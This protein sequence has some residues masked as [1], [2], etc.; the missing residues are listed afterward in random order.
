MRGL[1]RT[2]STSR[3]LNLAA[4]ASFIADQRALDERIRSLRR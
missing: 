4:L 1:E 3:V 2:A